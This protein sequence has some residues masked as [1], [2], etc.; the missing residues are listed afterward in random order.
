MWPELRII[1]GIDASM[2]TSEGTCR[3]VMP[4]SESTIAIAGPSASPASTAALMASPSGSAAVAVRRA[5]SP[6]LG[7]IPASASWAPY[8]SKRVGKNACTTWPKRIGSDTFIM[9]ALRCT[10]NSTSSA[11]A[12]AICSVRK[13]RSAATFMNVASTTS[14]ASTATS[15]FSTVVPSAVSSSIRRVSSWSTTTD[16]SLERK[17]SWPMVATLVLESLLHAPIRCGCAFA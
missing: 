12:R 8:C 10:E 4:R 1:A 7:E 9:V 3:L 16:F 11:L 17:S 2:I 15:S 6:S 5:P 14:P 13:R